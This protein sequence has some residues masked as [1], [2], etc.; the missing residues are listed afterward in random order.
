MPAFK[1]RPATLAS[2]LTATSYTDTTATAVTTY[3]YVVTAVNTI[4]ES[5]ASSL[6]TATPTSLPQGPSTFRWTSTGPLATPQNGSFAMKDWP[7]IAS[8]FWKTALISIG[9]P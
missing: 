3:D 8:S 6:S 5:A 2:G 7:S 1:A 9:S 4:G